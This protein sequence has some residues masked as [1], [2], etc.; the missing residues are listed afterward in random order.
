MPYAAC[1][2]DYERRVRASFGRQGVM[3]LIGAE[4]TRVEPGRVTIELPYRGELS[5]QHGFFHAG[6]TSTI[7]DSAG[8]SE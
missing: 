5:Q 1:D 4:L 2:P 6:I 7:A 3:L 8:G